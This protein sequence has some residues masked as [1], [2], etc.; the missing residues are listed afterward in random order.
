MKTATNVDN[1]T[2]Q[3]WCHSGIIGVPVQLL[4]DPK[5]QVWDVTGVLLCS[6]LI[7]SNALFITFYALLPTSAIHRMQ[8]Y[9]SAIYEM[10][11]PSYTDQDVLP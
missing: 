4:P 8:L 2:I 7:V 9:T 10:S 6:P 11:Q 3:S 5:K 1:H